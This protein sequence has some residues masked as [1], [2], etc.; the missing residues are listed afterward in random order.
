MDTVV[1]C[2]DMLKNVLLVFSYKLE[3]V[4]VSSTQLTLKKN[5]F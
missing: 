5:I 4:F 3:C 1:L 2:A